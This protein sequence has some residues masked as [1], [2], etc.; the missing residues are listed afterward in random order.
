MQKHAVRFHDRESERVLMVIPHSQMFAPRSFAVEATRKCVRAMYYNCRV[1]VRAVSE[2]ALN[3]VS[4]EAKLIIVPAARV[5]TESCWQALLSAANRGATVA[6]TGVIDE[7]EYWQH[8]DRASQL[9]WT[10]TIEPVLD[11]EVVR[12]GLRT[13]ELRYE[14]EKIQRIE[15]AVASRTLARVLVARHGSGRVVWSPLPLELSDSMAALKAF[16]QLALTH[17]HISPAFTVLPNTPS[18]LIIPAQFRD[19]LLYTFVSESDSATKLR[20]LHRAPARQLSVTIP[21]GR[22][23]MVLLDRKTG[24][25]ID[26]LYNS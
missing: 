8:V 21:A 4:V 1:P 5:L 19:A 15:K 25:L 11:S 24:E 13:F 12:I 17:A 2:Y 20:F 22:T 3:N 7:D 9:G 10:S 18:V 14:G 26:S 16:Y 23:N 6:I